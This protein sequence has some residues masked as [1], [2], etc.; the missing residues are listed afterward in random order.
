MR[1]F[2][3]EI[4]DEQLADLRERLARTR[5]PEQA[6]VEGW[7][8]GV[9]LDYAKEL[10]AYWASEYDWRRCEAELN[11]RPQFRTV[12]DGG[13]D[14]SLGVHF[15]HARSRH[16][17]ALPLLLTHGWP[18]SVVEFLGVLDAL[19]DP[20]DPAD[21]F[22]VVVPS[23]PGYGF[24]DKPRV[25]GWGVERIAT[26][27]AQLMDRLDYD[28]YGAQGGDWGSMVT[29]ALAI[30]VP[31]N[32]VGIHLTMPVASPPPEGEQQPLSESEKAAA[33]ASKV[34]QR[35]GTGYSAEQ[36]TRPQT[37]GYGL[38]DSPAA[39]CTWIVEKFWDWTDCA[40][41]PENVI[42]RDRLL[43][44]VML[45]WLPGT[46]ASSARLYWE[47]FGRRRLDQIDVPTGITMFPQ[48]LVR[49]PRH[50]LERR[51]TDLRHWSEQP[52]GGHFASLE[53]PEVFVD[54]LRTFFRPLRG[55]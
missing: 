50:W 18:G 51:F 38:L 49:L 46:G 36:S 15:I 40:G 11:S 5:W 39:Q 8:Q 9:P 29:S 34:F 33:A 43:D 13:G 20:P 25:D 44:N 4:P 52:T 23:L 31:E 54:E 24:S 7:T 55:S 22:H 26:A 3:V 6:T 16:P 14:D 47:S 45:Y 19:T 48:E 27:W 37:L 10:C 17:G 53:Q 1:E 12:L 28:R 41:H 32:L 30:G 35:Q 2:R 42:S 21:A